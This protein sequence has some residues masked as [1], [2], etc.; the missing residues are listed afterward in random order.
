MRHIEPHPPFR[1]IP[2][3]FL[4]FTTLLLTAATP[5]LPQEPAPREE[6][7]PSRY[8]DPHFT[9]RDS[10]V[11]ELGLDLK[12]LYGGEKSG[13]CEGWPLKACKFDVIFESFTNVDSPF[14]D[15]KAE[16]GFAIAAGGRAAGFPASTSYPYGFYD[17]LAV[18][19]TRTVNEV[20]DTHVVGCGQSKRIPY[21]IFVEE[22]DWLTANDSELGERRGELL[23]ECKPG[24]A[25]YRE[26]RRIDLF[27]NFGNVKHKVDV[28]LRT[29]VSNPDY[30]GT[31][32]VEGSNIEGGSCEIEV[33]F[34]R[35][36]HDEASEGR[37]RGIFLFDV[38]AGGE[39]RRLPTVAAG[40][41]QTY[42]FIHQGS[43]YSIDEQVAVHRIECGER[44]RVPV[45]LKGLESD[46]F[47]DDI[48]EAL[49][50][51][52]LTCPMKPAS[53]TIDLTL[54]GKLSGK[55]RH[56]LRAFFS[57][58]DL[59]WSE[60]NAEGINQCCQLERCPSACPVIGSF[61]GANCQVAEAPPLPSSPFIL[62]PTGFS[63]ELYY[64]PVNGQCTVGGWDTANCHV[65]SVP[66]HQATPFIW[67]R[68][69]YVGTCHGACP[70]ACP[71]IGTFDGANC[72]IATAPAGSQAF[73][74]NGAFYHSPVNGQC[75][76]GTFDGANCRVAEIPESTTP[77]IYA[78][79][80]YVEA[81]RP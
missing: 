22:E 38:S 57:A 23:L 11:R 34:D 68:H 5:L 75:A 43:T 2:S 24:V 36:F 65:A 46:G 26:N 69:L 3:P 8:S 45:K 70:T 66:A 20:I 80:F 37:G 79:G 18:G 52:D 15:K 14:G 28:V 49:F 35:I 61:D 59:G 53:S 56:Y 63:Y 74:W 72:Y 54:Y 51:I 33:R 41:K 40:A 13:E 42:Y 12:S 39:T 32:P 50:Y 62:N 81:C 67:N 19:A 16:Y 25:P 17:K 10:E 55:P 21:R 47:Y 76:L 7:S 1:R 27:N 29:E 64:T 60:F 78:N 73:I 44:R 77:F 58:R 30:C 9:E 31:V 4:L 71:Y 48:G 6:E